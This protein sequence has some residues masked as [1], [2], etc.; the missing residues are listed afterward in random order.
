MILSLFCSV[1]GVK[2]TKPQSLSAEVN[3]RGTSISHFL[4]LTFSHLRYSSITIKGYLEN[5]S[6]VSNVRV[7]IRPNYQLVLC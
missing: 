5:Y 6:L 3:F 2:I 7:K 4:I 1:T